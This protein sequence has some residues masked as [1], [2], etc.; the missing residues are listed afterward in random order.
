MVWGAWVVASALLADADVYRFQPTKA[1][2]WI[3]VAMI[4]PLAAALQLTRVPLASRILAQP[5]ALWRLTM[6]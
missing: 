5:D 2:P 1:L 3:P 6:P 4:V